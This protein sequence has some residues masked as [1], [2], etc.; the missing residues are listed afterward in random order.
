MLQVLNNIYA[1][2][3]IGEIPSH[4][5]RAAN[6]LKASQSSELATI[7]GALVIFLIG[8]GFALGCFIGRGQQ[9]NGRP[10]HQSRSDRKSQP[11]GS[12]APFKQAE[13]LDGIIMPNSYHVIEQQQQGLDAK[14]QELQVLAEEILPPDPPAFQ[15]EPAEWVLVQ[16]L[17]APAQDTSPLPSPNEEDS[18][19]VQASES[20]PPQA[21]GPPALFDPKL[22]AVLSEMTRRRQNSARKKYTVQ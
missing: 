4:G 22:T 5:E 18:L 7:I 13:S 11:H 14:D 16:S 20:K 1:S 8:G 3:V 12:R 6:A 10:H 15:E 9:Y 17:V 19:Q 2:Q 21:P